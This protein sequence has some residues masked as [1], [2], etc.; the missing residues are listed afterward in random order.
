ML[1]T[2]KI[3]SNISSGRQIHKPFVF[4]SDLKS[5]PK[6][7][8]QLQEDDYK[9][10]LVVDEPPLSASKHLSENNPQIILSVVKSFGV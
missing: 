5:I 9:T 10:I 2:K 4:I 7:V 6:L 8:Q 1:E 3:S